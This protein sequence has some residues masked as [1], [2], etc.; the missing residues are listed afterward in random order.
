M[1]GH[2]SIHV[3]MRSQRS[4]GSALGRCAKNSINKLKV[5]SI[6]RIFTYICN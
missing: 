3:S 2:T 6:A 1:G 5:R 4:R